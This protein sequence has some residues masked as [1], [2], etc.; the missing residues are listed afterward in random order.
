MAS[1]EQLSAWL[2]EAESALHSLSIGT[3]ARVVVDHN[4]ER[5]EFTATNT[6]KLQA[7]ITSLKRQLG[8]IGPAQPAGVIF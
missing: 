4:G 7:Y 1:Q 6:A 3:Q 5:V 8:M 2:Q